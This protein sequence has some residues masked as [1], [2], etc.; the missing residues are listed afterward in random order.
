MGSWQSPGICGSFLGLSPATDGEDIRGAVSSG[1]P[2]G[3]WTCEHASVS[4][5]H[6][7]AQRVRAWVAAAEVSPAGGTC[8]GAPVPLVALATGGRPASCAVHESARF[9]T[10]LFQSLESEAGAKMAGGGGSLLAR[11]GFR[12]WEGTVRRQESWLTGQVPAWARVRT[13]RAPA[14]RHGAEAMVAVR[15][16][17]TGTSRSPL[18]TSGARAGS[19]RLRAPSPGTFPQHPPVAR[20]LL[21]RWERTVS[22]GLL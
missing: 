4:N 22:P 1:P 2:T 21:G 5:K 20:E 18:P 11:R 16:R 9:F 14:P 10:R 13:L 7:Q 15:R 6:Q 3:A 19:S 17:C 12:A 8:P